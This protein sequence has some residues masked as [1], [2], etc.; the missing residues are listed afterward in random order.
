MK[1]ILLPVAITLLLTLFKTTVGVVIY[2]PNDYPTIQQAIDAAED[3]DI[4]VFVGFYNEN[5]IINKSLWFRP[6]LFTEETGSSPKYSSFRGATIN[7]DHTVGFNSLYIEEG[8]IKSYG[9][10]LKIIDC[11]FTGDSV[12][13]YWSGGEGGA[14]LC[15]NSKSLI[16]YNTI[17][18]YYFWDDPFPADKNGGKSW[19]KGTGICHNSGIAMISYNWV[20]DNTIHIVQEGYSYLETQGGGIYSNGGTILCNRV[21]DNT[22]HLWVNPDYGPATAIC[23]GGGIY[24]GSL[25][26]NNIIEGNSIFAYAHVWTGGQADAMAEGGGIYNDNGLIYNNLVRNNSSE[27]VAQGTPANSHAYGGGIFSNS[28]IELTTVTNNSCT[29]N[30]AGAGV[31]GGELLNSIVYF[32]GAQNI[33]GV[34]GTYSDVQYGL[35]GAGNI[36]AD[37][38]FTNQGSNGFFLSQTACGQPLQSP[39]VDAGGGPQANGTTR[40]D[41]VPDAGVVDMGFHYTHE[42]V[43]VNPTFFPSVALFDCIKHSVETGE[44]I[45]FSS[46]NVPYTETTGKYW[47]FEGGTPATSTQN[48]PFI[49]YNIP[50]DYKV[51]M[52]SYNVNYADTTI[53]DNCVHVSNPPTPPVP[54]FTASTTQPAIGETV[55]FTDLSTNNPTW[56]LWTFEGGTPPVSAVQNPIVTY[57][58]PGLYDVQLEVG[59]TYGSQVLLEEDYIDVSIVKANI[60]LFL[61]GPFNGTEMST[62]LNSY[63]YIPLSQPFNTSPWYYTGPETVTSIPGNEIT[64]WALLELRTGPGGPETATNVIARKAVFLSKDGILLPYDGTNIEFSGMTTDRIFAVIYQR[65]HLPVIS[66]DT[67]PIVNNSLTWDF[68]SDANMAYGGFL[69]QK[70]LAPGI[71]GLFAADGNADGQVNSQDKVDVWSPESGQSGYLSGDFNMNGNVENQD[72]NDL[73][74]INGGYGSFV[75]AAIFS[76]GDELIDIRDGK[77]YGTVLIGSRCWMS[78]NLNIGTMINGSSNQSNNS[79]IEKYCYANNTA[80]CD[81]YGGL[82]QWDEMMQYISTPGTQGICPPDWHIPTDIEWKKLEGAA[83]SQYSYPDPE[84]DQTGW[85]G[86][87]AGGNLKETG[88]DHWDNPNTGATNLTT[89]TA[90]PGGFRD[91][92]SVCL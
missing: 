52:I 3:G 78:E 57:N 67:L 22:M 63:G 61:E 90:L 4:I 70:E 72:K 20:F 8:S 54:A 71:W 2:V 75:P 77:V 50:G 17:Y 1:K 19:C 32:N 25:V 15:N 7:G 21:F 44:T 84:W 38:L 23:K 5:L 28:V 16:H 80:H 66:P 26:M 9:G 53:I 55:H 73:W 39:C 88:T 60:K 31:Y 6:S 48:N 27:A 49:T 89:F 74:T 87:D 11:Y 81:E 18:D 41:Y 51:T 42:W 34:T 40:T 12:Y 58:T 10:T 37:P 33:Y 64:D 59:N 24:G 68:T 46:L 86:Y 45:Q 36:D 79:I 92:N 65:N 85:R 14:I 83:D 47:I 13:T 35:T 30:A 29:G 43:P 91:I 69:A 56:W 82:Y 62:W 76:C